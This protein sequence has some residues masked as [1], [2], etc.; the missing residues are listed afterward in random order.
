MKYLNEC[1]I[2]DKAYELGTESWGAIQK[3]GKCMRCHRTKQKK[4]K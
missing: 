3:I 4:L 2:C 1:K